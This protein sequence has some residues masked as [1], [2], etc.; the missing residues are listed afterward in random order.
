MKP[1]AKL[2]LFSVTFL[3]IN[4]LALILNAPL[5][6]QQSKDW[7]IA[8]LA[9]NSYCVMLFAVLSVKFIIESVRQAT[10]NGHKTGGPKNGEVTK[11]LARVRDP[12]LDSRRGASAA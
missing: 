7:Q 3:V 11:F 10:P 9:I 6:V 12:V 1:S 8:L 5:W 2:A 4:L